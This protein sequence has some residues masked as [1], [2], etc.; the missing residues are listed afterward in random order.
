MPER[1]C[2]TRKY[3]QIGTDKLDA[4]PIYALLTP[5]EIR[6]FTK[7]FVKDEKKT[8]PE[9]VNKPCRIKEVDDKGRAISYTGTQ[10][11]REKY[12]PRCVHAI[13]RPLVVVQWK[14]SGSGVSVDVPFLKWEGKQAKSL[15][16][17]ETGLRTSFKQAGSS[18]R[19][20]FAEV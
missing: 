10:P 2:K 19:L 11:V 9:R 16:E 7:N 6:T 17:V 14:K 12:V 3:V 18:V 5:R 1:P 4:K 20:S 13:S 15:R 8:F